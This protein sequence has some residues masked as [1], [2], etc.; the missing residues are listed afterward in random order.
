LC[1]LAPDRRLEAGTS[2]TI[3]AMACGA[4]FGVEALTLDNL[5]RG[6]GLVFVEAEANEDTVY[7]SMNSGHAR[8]CLFRNGLT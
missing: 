5:G 6:R 8:P 3:I 2:P 1:P 7:Q 4:V